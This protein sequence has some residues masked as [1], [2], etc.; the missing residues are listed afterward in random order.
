[1]PRGPPPAES[2]SPG[3]RC[4][5]ARA[6][7]ARDPQRPARV[8]ALR[9]PRHRLRPVRAGGSF[10]SGSGAVI[11]AVAGVLAAGVV[12]LA[13]ELRAERTLTPPPLTPRLQPP[14][15]LLRL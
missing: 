7:P 15:A 8:P 13:A 4:R 14:R 5:D 11:W 6:R 3:P 9:L 10:V 2:R 12:L 1:M